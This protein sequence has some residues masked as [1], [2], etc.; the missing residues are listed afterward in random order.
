[1]FIRGLMVVYDD[2][3]VGGAALWNG[4]MHT[5]AKGYGIMYVYIHVAIADRIWCTAD[6]GVVL[7]IC[8]LQIRN[9]GKKREMCSITW[10]VD[11]AQKHNGS[12]LLF[13]E[14]AFLCALMSQLSN[15][16]VCSRTPSCVWDNTLRTFE[17]PVWSCVAVDT[18]VR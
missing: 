1:M 6:V 16:A 7:C 17:L 4:P 5:C 2:I 15:G 14:W 13:D 3:A 11:M 8:L 18:F 9:M 12:E 10:C